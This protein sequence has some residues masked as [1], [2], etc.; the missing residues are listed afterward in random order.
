[1]TAPD[2]P[3]ALLHMLREIEFSSGELG[4]SCPM[5]WTN[6]VRTRGQHRAGCSL[7]LAIVALEAKVA[8]PVE[9]IAE[10]IRRA[11]V[12]AWEAAAKVVEQHDVSGR[13]WLPGTLWDT[14]SKE[15]GARIRRLIAAEP[16]LVAAPDRS[17]ISHE[18]DHKKG[19]DAG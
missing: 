5:C 17:A 2:D 6:T 13:E 3:S 18:A 12:E 14:L 9:P 15:A 7:H 10:T 4:C 8:T 16:D 11:K 19:S 1:M